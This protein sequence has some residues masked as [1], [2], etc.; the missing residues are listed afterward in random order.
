MNTRL[1]PTCHEISSLFSIIKCKLFL[2]NPSFGD[3]LTCKHD[4]TFMEYARNF[5]I[6]ND[7]MTMTGYKAE[8]IEI[9]RL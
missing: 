6:K 1:D 3:D 9:Y 8:L 5:F 7:K 4:K 2:N